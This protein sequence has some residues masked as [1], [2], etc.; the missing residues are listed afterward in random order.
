MMDDPREK[1][2]KQMQNEF[3]LTPAL[4]ELINDEI[5]TFA[6]EGPLARPAAKGVQDMQQR[7]NMLRE[8]KSKLL[9]AMDAAAGP[10]F[11]ELEHM[12]NKLNVSIQDAEKRLAEYQVQ[13]KGFN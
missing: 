4:E 12:L 7:L 3:P 13:G 1:L 8:D 2:L 9:I 5:R 10:A 6:G 11:K